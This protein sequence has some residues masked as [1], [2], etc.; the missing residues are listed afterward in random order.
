MS[1]VVK[2]VTSQLMKGKKTKLGKRTQELEKLV[3]KSY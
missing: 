2:N 1:N 3:K